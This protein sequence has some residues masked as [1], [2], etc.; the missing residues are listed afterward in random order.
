MAGIAS[1]PIFHRMYASS[2]IMSDA[3]RNAID[4]NIES[5]TKSPAEGGPEMGLAIALLS[6][7]FEAMI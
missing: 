6:K 3:L 1:P 7:G 4:R 5:L 2:R